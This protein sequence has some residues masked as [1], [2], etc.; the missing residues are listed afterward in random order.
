[1]KRA[2]RSGSLRSMP[3]SSSICLKITSVCPENRNDKIRRTS[4]SCPARTVSKPALGHFLYRLSQTSLPFIFR[5]QKNPIFQDRKLIS[6]DEIGGLICLLGGSFIKEW[7]RIRSS[8]VFFHLQNRA[9]PSDKTAAR[10]SPCSLY[11]GIPRA[12]RPSATSSLLSAA[13]LIML[14]I[15]RSSCCG[16]Q[17]LFGEGFQL[18]NVH[19][20]PWKD[21]PVILGPAPQCEH[22]TSFRPPAHIYRLFV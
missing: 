21:E 12:D 20:A 10:S 5:V 8:S 11:R 15:S 6:P 2:K 22:P 18:T 14:I 3:N 19:G 1:M 9:K 4:I 17:I 13:R 16:V 7:R